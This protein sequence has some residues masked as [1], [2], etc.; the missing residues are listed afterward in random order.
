MKFGVR[1]IAEVVLRAK[2][3][4]RIGKR[5][6]YRN[7]PVIYFDSL[8]T[9]SLEGAATTNYATGGRGN[10]RLLAWEGERTLTFSM[11][12]ALIS[13]ESF[14]ILSGAGLIDA[15]PTKGEG[16]DILYVHT[17]SQVQA[18]APNTII[19]PKVACWSHSGEMAEGYYHDG[20]D[21]F[22]MVLDSGEIAGEPCIP[23]EQGVIHGKMV[24][25]EFTALSEGDV[26]THT[27]ILCTNHGAGIPTGAVVLVDYYVKRTAG[28]KQIEITPDKFGGYFYL[29][30]STLWRR[31][32]DGVDLPA[33]LIIPKVKI[34]SNFTFTM[35][36][37]GDPSTFDFVMDAFPD[38]TKFDGTKKV[39]A[40]L[41]VVES[42]DD[43][44]A[45]EDLVRRG[46][47]NT[48]E[49]AGT[50]LPTAEEG[51]FDH[52]KTYGE[53]NHFAIDDD[54]D[55]EY[56][57]ANYP[58]DTDPQALVHSLSLDTHSKSG[59]SAY[60]YLD[61]AKTTAVTSAKV[62]ATVY[63][64]VLEDQL[65]DIITVKTVEGDVIPYTYESSKPTG[66]V[67][68]TMPNKGVVVLV[69]AAG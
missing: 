29:E 8:T 46:H 19:I 50:V 7:D 31:E 36:S 40:M 60:F 25:G 62:G 55:G 45:G 14:M 24:N 52:W 53:Q 9:S 49:E 56:T 35:A 2:A 69:T 30:G 47:C 5:T 33:E 58:D 66:L 6:F 18:V 27:K 43:A 34:Q 42:E 21:I 16:T 15:A 13:P 59:V 39:L 51:E 26:P 20:A 22:C 11:T 41:Q 44:S 3:K 61:N 48:K 65:G 4:Q 1:E 10:T 57:N 67:K 23:V 63:A 12:D 28:V 32:S 54:H 37:N 68:F 17:T 38:Y 64:D